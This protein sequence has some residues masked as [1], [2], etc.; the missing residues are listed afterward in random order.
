[1]RLRVYEQLYSVN[2][3]LTEASNDLEALAKTLKLDRT[4]VQLMLHQIDEVR[5]DANCSLAN[6][7][8]DHELAAARKH[9]TRNWRLEDLHR[10]SHS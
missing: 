8:N 7:I 4:A 10:T 9:P 5:R 2:W 1:M 3:H 6:K